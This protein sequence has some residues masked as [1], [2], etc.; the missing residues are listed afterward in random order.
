[1]TERETLKKWL[2][3]SSNIVF[4]GGAGVSTESHIPDFRSTDGLYNQQYDYPP[5]TILSH[6]FYMEK[7]EE[8]F[9]TVMDELDLPDNFK[10]SGM[11]SFRVTPRKDRVDVFVTKTDLKEDLDFNDLSDME[12]YSGLSP[13]EFLKALEDNFMD[14][15]DI[16]A[17]H[18]LE[19][20]D[21][22]LKEVDETMTE[23]AKEVAEETIREDYTHYV[24]AFSDFDQVVTFAQG[25]KNV[26]VEGSELYKLGD[27]YY[28]TILLYLADEPDYY[29]NNMYARFLEYA[30]VADRT[31]PYLQEHATILMEEDALPVL[32]ATKW[33]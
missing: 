5:E 14:K 24:L 26:S 18:K 9:Y 3:E 11:L 25:L 6:T 27:V 7:T 2:D 13:E 32:Q 23:P 10:N 20:H 12:D 29:A 19:E 30:N 16:E 4:F 15:G 33:S 8:F 21:K 1:M 17:H 31:R 22:T 28:M